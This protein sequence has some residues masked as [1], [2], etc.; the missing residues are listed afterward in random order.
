MVW[1][2]TLIGASTVIK[3]LPSLSLMTFYNSFARE[4][5]GTKYSVTFELSVTLTRLRKSLN[6][7]IFTTVDISV[8]LVTRN[9]MNLA[10]SLL[11]NSAAGQF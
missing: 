10:P 2:F 8:C 6:A 4:G 3:L 5:V 9:P 7:V 1:M 11:K